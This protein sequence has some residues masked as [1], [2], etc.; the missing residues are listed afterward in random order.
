MWINVF[1]DGRIYLQKRIRH[2]AHNKLTMTTLKEDTPF[3]TEKRNV[4][5]SGYGTLNFNLQNT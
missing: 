3:R 5:G 4:S 1:T 2:I